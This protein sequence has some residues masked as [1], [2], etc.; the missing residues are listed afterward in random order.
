[1][2]KSNW[3]TAKEQL[4]KEAYQA[5]YNQGLQEGRRNGQAEYDAVI[6]RGEE[7]C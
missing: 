4:M 5:G 2:E 1:M 6:G 7:N 3:E